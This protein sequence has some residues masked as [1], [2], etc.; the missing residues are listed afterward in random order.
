MFIWRNNQKGHDAPK[1][2]VICR[3]R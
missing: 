2:I 1:K 3:M